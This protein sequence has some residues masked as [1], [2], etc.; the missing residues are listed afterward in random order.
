MTDQ[1]KVTARRRPRLLVAEDN[2][3]N[4]K[5]A[6]A[7]LERI[8]YEAEVAVNG[9][10]A[11]ECIT[12][13][14]YAAVLMDCQMPEMDGYEATAAIRQREEADMSD[15][16]PIIAMTAAAM[17]GDKERCLAAGMDDYIP[18]PVKL[19]EL[20]SVLQRWIVDSPASES[21]ELPEGG[22]DRGHRLHLDPERIEELRQLT[23]KENRDGFTVIADSFLEDAPPRVSALE[24]AVGDQNAS[25][26]AWEAHALKGASANLGATTFSAI[27]KQMEVAA[28]SNDF[29]QVMNLLG[30]LRS[31]F[32]EVKKAVAAEL[33]A[34]HVDRQEKAIHF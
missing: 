3:V 15:R 12:H 19:A 4:Q 33:L 11:V 1:P 21:V 24:Q 13:N 2:P 29:P 22:R 18:K 20:H 6:V 7:M 23:D 25:V 31:E 5:V 28:A 14:K 8:G 34:E 17:A 27:C 9:L 10:E 26:V 32:D 16:T 30:E